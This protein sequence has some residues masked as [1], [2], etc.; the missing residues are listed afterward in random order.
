M[1]LA[2]GSSL[3]VVETVQFPLAGWAAWL[4]ATNLLTGEATQPLPD[5]LRNAIERLKFY[6]NNGFGDDFGRRQAR[7]ILADLRADGSLD[8]DAILGALLAA[9]VSAR[10]IG[11]L[12]RVIEKLG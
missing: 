11:Q 12:G 8:Q 9:G 7:T 10:G 2:R 3:A 6:G 4:E 5:N 1:S